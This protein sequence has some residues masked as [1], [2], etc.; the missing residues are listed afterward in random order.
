MAPVL[1]RVLTFRGC[2]HAA[3]AMEAVRSAATEAGAAVEIVEVDLLGS[4]TP[5]DLRGLP[6]PTVLVGEIDASGVTTR[7]EGASCRASGSPTVGQI[8]DAIRVA[9]GDP[10]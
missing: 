10:A 6:S 8:R 5:V 1:I 3:A 4:D 9:L 7:T 2:P